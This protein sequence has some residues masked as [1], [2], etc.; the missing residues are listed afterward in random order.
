MA[1]TAVA[2]GTA[3]I[4]AGRH[5][6]GGRNRE[7]NQQSKAHGEQYTFHSSKIYS[8]SPRWQ[9]GSLI[10]GCPDSRT[11]VGH[12]WLANVKNTIK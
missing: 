7:E 5:G 12:K 8:I 9:E 1:I 4:A 10:V 11:I 2:T 3:F 6:G